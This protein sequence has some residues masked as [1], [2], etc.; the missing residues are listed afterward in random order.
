M[1]QHPRQAPWEAPRRE[2]ASTNKRQKTATSYAVPDNAQLPSW[3]EI[4]AHLTYNSKSLGKKVEVIVE[5]VDTAR[6]EVELSFE[7]EE[8]GQARKILPFGVIL[9]SDNPLLGPWEGSG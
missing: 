7:M 2:L 3:I 8:G 1:S 5:M 6:C 4:D 9:S